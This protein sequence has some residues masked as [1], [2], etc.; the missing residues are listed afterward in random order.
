M[1]AWR[2]SPAY[3]QVSTTPIDITLQFTDHWYGIMRDKKSS[4][5]LPLRPCATQQQK[6]L[7]SISK[8]L[9]RLDESFLSSPLTT[10]EMEEAINH[11]RGHSSPG[12]DGLPAAFYRLAPSV[13]GK[14]LKIVFE[15]QLRRGSLL[16]SQRSSAITLLYKKKDPVLI[17]ATIV[18]LP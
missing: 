9:S 12:M 11:M 13:F 3:G 4:A 2:K 6:L 10:R 5:G 16:R 18:L 8:T 14:C 1:Y 17:L 7:Q 15:H